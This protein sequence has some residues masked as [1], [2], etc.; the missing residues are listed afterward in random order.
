MS[1]WPI[2]PGCEACWDLGEGIPGDDYWVWPPGTGDGQSPSGQPSYILLHLTLQFGAH[3]ELL[4]NGPFHKDFMKFTSW[5]QICPKKGGGYPVHCSFPQPTT[6]LHST[7]SGKVHGNSAV[8]CI[9]SIMKGALVSSHDQWCHLFLPSL[10]SH[11]WQR[12]VQDL[13]KIATSLTRGQSYQT[14][15]SRVDLKM[16][17]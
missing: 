10:E 1:F 16:I 13:D 9:Y 2:L 14:K 8:V 4:V 3:C 11:V 6:V 12:E 7:R 15:G 5:I 17:W